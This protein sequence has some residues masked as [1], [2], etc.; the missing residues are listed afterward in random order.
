MG[1]MRKFGLGFPGRLAVPDAAHFNG[2]RSTAFAPV[3]LRLVERFA[4]A[5]G[6]ANEH[7]GGSLVG[8]ACFLT[9]FALLHFDEFISPLGYG[10]RIETRRHGLRCHDGKR[11][12]RVRNRMEAAQKFF[13][14]L[15]QSFDR[16][17]VGPVGAAF[18]GDLDQASGCHLLQL[19]AIAARGYFLT[20]SAP[21]RGG[22]H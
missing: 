18:N 22:G 4:H 5:A 6:I 3:P 19:P 12:L 1:F 7:Q 16:N 13:T 11:R 21:R 10:R 15:G 2:G 14:Q 9:N 20:W 17:G 8:H